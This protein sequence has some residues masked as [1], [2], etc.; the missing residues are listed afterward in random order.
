MRRGKINETIIMNAFI[1][2]KR[3]VS[4]IVAVALGC[5]ELSL[6]LQ[7]VSPPPDGGYPGGNTEEGQ[8]ALLGLTAGTFNMAIGIF[9]LE[10]LRAGNFCTGVGLEPCLRIPQTRIQQQ[11]SGRFSAT[12]PPFSTG[13]WGI[14]PFQ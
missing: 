12:R 9:S 11:A 10:T 7:A 3:R 13:E 14:H 5:F 4:L 2:F 1:Q 8:N 6:N